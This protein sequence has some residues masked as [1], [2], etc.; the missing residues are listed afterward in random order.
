MTKLKFFEDEF[1]NAVMTDLMST[2]ANELNNRAWEFGGKYVNSA[3]ARK[4]RLE[5]TL[6][7]GT[8]L[9]IWGHEH[10]R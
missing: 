1:V 7:D 6:D 8:V 3:V 5:V 9:W 4:E 2:L 10:K